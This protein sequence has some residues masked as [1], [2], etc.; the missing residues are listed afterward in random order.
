MAQ[1]PNL[2]SEEEKKRAVDTL[3]K[4]GVKTQ[5]PMCSN[6]NFI[7]AE[8]YFNQTM[9][10]NFHGGLI[11]GGPSIPSVAI[12]CTNCGFISHHALGALGLLQNSEGGK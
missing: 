6:N 5:C 1:N 4:K 8:G 10:G 3:T 12:V 11:L 7:L 9:Q 2:M